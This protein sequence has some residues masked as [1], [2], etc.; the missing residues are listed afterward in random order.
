MPNGIEIKNRIKIGVLK[1]NIKNY[2]SQSTIR[3]AAKVLTAKDQKKVLAVILIQIFL[4]LLD[5]LGVALVGILGTLAIS[6]IQSNQPES[7]VSA[8]LELLHLDGFRIQQQVA[9]MGIF[10]ATV[11]IGRT[12][13]SAILIKKIMF[14]LSRRGAVVS[15]KLVSKLFSQSIM[16]V[17]S[18]SHQSSLFSVT[19]GVHSITNG[20]L[21]STVALVSDASLLII[22]SVGLFIYDPWICISSFALFGLV[23]YL[24]FKSMHEK[25]RNL[26]ST[27]TVLMIESNELIIELLNSYREAV[28]RKR[29]Q[30]YFNSFFE[31]RTKLA[32]SEAELNFMPNV[33]KYVFE[34]TMVFGAL[35]ICGIQ[36][37]LKDA[38]H[39]VATLAIFIAAAT[40]IAPAILRM[41]QGALQIRNGLGSASATLDLIE[42]L[43]NSP[44]LEVASDKLETNHRDFDSSILLKNVCFSYSQ[45]QEDTISQVSVEINP[46]SFCAIVGPSGAGKTTLVDLILGILTPDSGE[47]FISGVPAETSIDKWPGA[48]AYVPQETYIANGTIRENIL[49]GY[50]Q[51]VINDT[52]L[53]EI[54]KLTSLWDLVSN[55]PEGLNTHLGQSGMRLSGG[56][57]QRLG[58]ARALV[59]NPAIIVLDE[60]TSALDGQLEAEITAALSKLRGQVTMIVIA[61]RL[62]TIR[63]A[64]RI[65]YLNKGKLL[66][67]GNFHEVRDQIPD[68]DE[69]AKL[70]GL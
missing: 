24:L 21:G 65:L 60:A 13:F 70:M 40:R 43:E 42:E 57:R 58:I 22:M 46:G 51:D 3:R 66:A 50:P 54:L 55:M 52:Y 32:N 56:Q 14:F 38:P 16:K 69:Q 11:L 26:G 20:I 4:G 12:V 49:L 25:A 61:H 37:A 64:D 7:R 53:E 33:S 19:T 29:R 59:T 47:I 41:Q 45:D 5:L 48:V 28:V 15:G 23:G 35:I 36:F 68:F 30:Y 17:N 2:W 67:E 31:L 1:L 10:A 63:D 62:S 6:G 34:S 27:S 18:V 39:A 44:T 9:F 8:A